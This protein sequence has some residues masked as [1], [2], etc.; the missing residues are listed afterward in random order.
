MTVTPSS[1]TPSTLPGT[2]ERTQVLAVMCLALILVVANVSMLNVALRDI[3]LDL[4]A[5]ATQQ[6]WI[7]DSYAVIF[8]ALLLPF[9]AVGDRYGRRTVMLIG[10]SVTILA[11]AMAAL[12]NSAEILIAARLLSGFGAAMIMPGTLASITHVFPP[13]ERGKAVGTWAGFASSGGIIGLL[14]A[15]IALELAEWP[16]IFWLVSVVTVV[17]L[18]GTLKVV[19]NS[20]DPKS[21]NIDP[22]GSMLS[23]VGIAALVFGIIEGPVNGWAS[24]LVVSAF[25]VA[26]GGIVGF[27]VWELR[28][29]TPVL[30]VRL[31]GNRAFGA[32]SLSIFVQFFAAFG[33]FYVAIQF[34]QGMLGYS[35]LTSAICLA[36]MGALVVPVSAA[37]P[38]IA[39]RFGLKLVNAAGLAAMATGFLVLSLLDESSGYWSFLIGLGLFGTGMAFSTAPASESIINSLPKS[40]H[41][42]A[43]AVNDTTRELGGAIG[44][45]VIGSAFTSGYRDTFLS[46]SADFPAQFVELAASSPLTGLQTATEMVSQLGSNGRRFIEEVQ[47]SFMSGFTEAMQIGAIILVAGAIFVLWRSPRNVTAPSEDL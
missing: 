8:A 6:H 20:K 41:G 19:P 1:P 45:A 13:N 28:T 35:P 46:I 17:A 21:A 12:A 24:T 11:G 25:V 30:D 7:V 15:G 32:G 43:S 4:G 31:F 34:L 44:I 23:A 40:Q 10:M 3:G 9:G 14:V 26:A 47:I 16:A 38:R 2:A 36:P 5:T 27:L 22:F 37:A 18:L 42:V 39:R 33:F 29:A